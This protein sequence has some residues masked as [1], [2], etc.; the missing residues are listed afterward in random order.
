MGVGTD[1]T[2][3]WGGQEKGTASIG[4]TLSP[5]CWRFSHD[6]KVWVEGGATRAS[7]LLYKPNLGLHAPSSE[8]GDHLWLTSFH[9][10]SKEDEL[11]F[12]HLA[13]PGKAW[14]TADQKPIKSQTGHPW[15]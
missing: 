2:D 15:R 3:E 12:K 5:L 4:L 9:C 14:L 10:L 6:G 13:N 1:I 11:P 8:F 7:L